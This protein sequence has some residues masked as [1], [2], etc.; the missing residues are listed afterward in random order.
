MAFYNCSAIKLIHYAG[1]V[2]DFRRILIGAGNEALE[3]AVITYSST[4]DLFTE[5]SVRDETVN[6]SEK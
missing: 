6:A 3:S 1:G 4:A 2:S 5:G